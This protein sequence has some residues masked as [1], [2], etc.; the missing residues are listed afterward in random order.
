LD[1][2][3]QQHFGGHQ[4]Q[5]LR[6]EAQRFA[7]GFDVA[8]TTKAS[9]LALRD[10]WMHEQDDQFRIPG[11][12]KQLI[13]YLQQQCINNGVGIHTSCAAKVIDWQKGSVKVT[14]RDGRTFTGNKVIITI[15]VGVWQTAS[16]PTGLQLEPAVPACRQALENIGYG[17]VIKVLIRFKEAFWRE[18]DSEIGFLLSE[19]KIPTWWT[20]HPDPTPLLTGWVGGA[21]ASALQQYDDATLYQ[22][23]LQSLGNI[24]SMDPAQLQLQVTAWHVA[25]WAHNVFSAGAY[26]YNMLHT[27]HARTVLNQPIEQT[28]YFAGEGYY[29][30]TSG[31]TVEAALSSA[32][33]VADSLP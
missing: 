16:E 7:E 20:Q 26:T 11:G 22:L 6:N 32:Q 18:R 3:L 23:A 15:P 25:N 10:E 33:R 1:D 28:I 12:Y 14:A 24:F 8:D 29:E 5:T 30:G 13:Q 19:E 2:F 31:G 9:V 17:S 27:N 21:A 4:Y